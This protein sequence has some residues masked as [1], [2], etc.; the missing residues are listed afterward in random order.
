MRMIQKK[1]KSFEQRDTVI[2]GRVNRSTWQ[3]T[4]PSGVTS[5]EA[6]DFLWYEYLDIHTKIKG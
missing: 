2:N 4:I 1:K 6:Y 5:Y 3:S